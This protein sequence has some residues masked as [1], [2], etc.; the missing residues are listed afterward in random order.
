MNPIEPI[1]RFAL[2]LVRPGM[3]IVATPFFGGLYAPV[4]MRIGLTMLLAFVLTPLVPVPTDLSMGALGAIVLRE[5]LIGLAIALGVRVLIVAAEA[6]GQLLGY[7]IGLSYGSMIDPQSGVRN[8]VLASLYATLATVLAFATGVHHQII[9]AMTASYNALPIGFGGVDD[10]LVAAT[11]RLL[12]LVLVLGIRIVAPVIVVLLL[13]EALLGLMARVAPSFNLLAVGSPLRLAV[14]L[15][16]IAATLATLPPILSR[17]VPVSLE[18][19]ADLAK[20][21]R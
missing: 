19:A 4:Q 14:G 7:Q 20:A 13:T 8:S 11:A 12:G 3:L 10:R 17:Y 1:I 9:R 2:L 6:A 5:V 15:L 21:F 18:L 16:V